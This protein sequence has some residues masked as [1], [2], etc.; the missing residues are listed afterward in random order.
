MAERI[1]LTPKV[2]QSPFDQTTEKLVLAY[3]GRQDF[4]RTLAL[5][6][7]I[8]LGDPGRNGWENLDRLLT[9]DG[10]RFKS[11]IDSQMILGR[12]FDYAC[13]QK[14]PVSK[15]NIY[16]N[17]SR[18]YSRAGNVPVAEETLKLMEIYGEPD[19]PYVHRDLALA[20]AVQGKDPK[21]LLERAHELALKGDSDNSS[22]IN[23][24]A[25]R[26]YYL[27]TIAVDY[28]KFGLDP[29]PLLQEA[30]DLDRKLVPQGDPY[31]MSSTH[32]VLA[33]AFAV[34]GDF[35]TAFGF[36]DEIEGDTDAQTNSERNDLRS[37]IAHVFLEKGQIGAALKTA[38]DSGDDLLVADV[39]TEVAIRQ[40]QKGESDIDA[41]I[42]EVLRRVDRVR[43]PLIQAELYSSL[44][45]A[46]A[47]VSGDPGFFFSE[48]ME[49]VNSS[50]PYHAAIKTS[51]AVARDLD[52][53]GFD[54]T[55]ILNHA[56]EI[57]DQ[58]GPEGD[59]DVHGIAEQLINWEDVMEHTAELGYF[60]IARAAFSRL[61]RRQSE[62]DIPQYALNMAILAHA[63]IQRGL[64]PEEIQSLTRDEVSQIF[65]G[66]N[67]EAKNAARYFSID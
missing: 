30:W 35:K 36:V 5:A 22:T 15:R 11:G 47:L 8:P 43:N 66:Q 49:R 65:D 38:F 31:H 7:A 33:K 14:D 50:E 40:A 64:Q 55:S 32:S 61:E 9:I 6:E 37:K 57:A 1:K 53:S 20:Y 24:D 21:P 52:A 60:D 13:R 23:R 48:A 19:S 63:E 67:E 34:H 44:G 45:R 28:P 62:D 3:Q 58:D 16:E 56:L 12:V 46:S 42:A 29:T 18:S 4:A 54:A 27:S 59:R 26:V 39:N 10:L 2:T 51:V 25:S 17:M 41:P